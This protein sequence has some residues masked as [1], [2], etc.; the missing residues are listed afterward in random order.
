MSTVITVATPAPPD[1]RTD[2]RTVRRYAAAALLPLG[3]LSVAIL[4]GV[5]PYFH[6]GDSRQTIE[7]TAGNLGRQ[8]AVLWLSL[9]AILTL[10]PS[11][12]AAGRLAQRHAPVLSLLGVGLLMSGYLSLPFAAGDPTIRTLAGGLVDHGT[13][14]RLLDQLN[15]LAPVGIAEVIFI[16]GH[17]LGTVLLGAALWR[18]HA[19]PTW[20]AI[21]IIV[22]QPL[23]LVSFVVLGNQPLDVC[24]WGLTALGLGVAAARVLRTPNDSW[25]LPPVA[26]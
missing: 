2:T 26:R 18:A 1:T 17:I 8:D 14:A 22:S 16:V 10:V 25:D 5:L 3:P 6:A 7:Q 19:V 23:H 24:A 9:V 21:A 13:A 15:G 4:R 11:A 12:V 20:A